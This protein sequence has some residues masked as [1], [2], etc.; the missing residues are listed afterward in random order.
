MSIDGISAHDLISHEAMSQTFADVE[1]GSQTLPF[2]FVFCG[3]PSHYLGGLCRQSTHYQAV[4]KRRAR[5][6]NDAVVVLLDQ[7]HDARARVGNVEGLEREFVVQ[8]GDQGG[9]QDLECNKRET[10]M[11]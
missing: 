6:H 8:I 10:P 9:N 4:R 3:A 2:V 1:R 11:V 7:H 5:R